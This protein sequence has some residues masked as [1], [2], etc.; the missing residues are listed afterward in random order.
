MP[1]VFPLLPSAETMILL[2]TGLLIA[3]R[4]P[5]YKSAVVGG[6]EKAWFRGGGMA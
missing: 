3:H 6:V 5:K 1:S 2:E 4:I